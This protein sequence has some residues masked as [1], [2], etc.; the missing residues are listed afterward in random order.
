MKEYF[1][2]KSCKI[3]VMKSKNDFS[4]GV[5][6]YIFLASELDGMIII[7]NYAS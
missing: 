4:Y 1:N 2:K 5:T 6:G 3:L 7:V